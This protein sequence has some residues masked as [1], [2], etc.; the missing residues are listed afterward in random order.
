MVLSRLGFVLFLLLLL[1]FSALAQEEDALRT[2]I[3]SD[4]MTDPRSA[5]MSPIELD[6]LVDALASQAEEQG[7]AGEYLEAQNSFDDVPFE[8]PVYE[9]PATSPYD[10]LSIAI[11][12]F[13]LVLLGVWI[14]LAVQ[15]KK[16]HTSAPSDG[17]VA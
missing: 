6:V 17:M 10:A 7:V 13:F 3:R 14:F 15:R 5:E 16:H 2:A 4:I 11:G 1:P 12:A 8:A 9:P